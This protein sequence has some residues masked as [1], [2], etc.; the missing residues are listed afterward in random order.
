MRV[1]DRSMEYNVRDWS[2]LQDFAD[3]ERELRKRGR[4]GIVTTMPRWLG[5][6]WRMG[7][8]LEPLRKPSQFSGGGDESQSGKDGEIVLNGDGWRHRPLSY[9]AHGVAERAWH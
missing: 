6:S 2:Q 5:E 9:L 7:D 3:S 8:Q 1:G 4:T